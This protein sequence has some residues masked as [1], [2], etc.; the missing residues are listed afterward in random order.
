MIELVAPIPQGQR[1][2]TYVFK[3]LPENISYSKMVDNDGKPDCLICF[4]SAFPYPHNSC[5]LERC[6]AAKRRRRD[7]QRLHVD[8]SKEPWHSKPEAYWKPV[9]DW[10]RLPGV[11]G[12]LRPTTAFKKLTPSANWV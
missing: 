7:N 6:I 9:V 12:F 11:K 8:L 3:A 4:R 5:Q 1:L 10:L 2:M